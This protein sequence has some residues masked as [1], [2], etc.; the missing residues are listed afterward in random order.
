MRGAVASG[1]GGDDDFYLSELKLLLRRIE[2]QRA[3]TSELQPTIS[4]GIEE[5]VEVGVWSR[6][7]VSVKIR[8][9][10]GHRG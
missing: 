3:V 6:V 9:W 7:R 8:V 5:C 2:A 1:S 4:A 10:I